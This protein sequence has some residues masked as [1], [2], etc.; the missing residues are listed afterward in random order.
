MWKRGTRRCLFGDWLA[1]LEAASYSCP[2][3]DTITG[4]AIR[5]ELMGMVV[6]PQE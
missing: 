5:G 2:A 6:T 3:R 4:V 1:D